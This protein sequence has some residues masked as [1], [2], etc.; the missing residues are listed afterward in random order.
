MTPEL[1]SVT[2]CFAAF[3]P[4][5]PPTYMHRGPLRQLLHHPPQPE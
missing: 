3:D 4:R 2:V 5:L 1:T